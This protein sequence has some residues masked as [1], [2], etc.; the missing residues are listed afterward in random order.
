[1]V[2]GLRL[3]AN[4]VAALMFAGV[5]VIFCAKI[6]MRYALHDEMAWADEVSIILFIW[7]I[8]WAN[9]FILD[10]PDHIRFDLVTHAAPPRLR[11]WMAVARS[12]LI[13]GVFLYATPATFG[14]IRFLWRERTPVLELPLDWVYLCFGVFVLSVPVRSGW[15]VWRV[16]RGERGRNPKSSGRQVITST[17]PDLSAD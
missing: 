11:R 8:F 13:G 4:L 6:V 17:A 2:A 16:M 7:I 3:F 9:A 15:S 12:L 5:F 1:M 14:Y 10:E